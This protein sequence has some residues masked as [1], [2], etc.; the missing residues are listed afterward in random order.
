MKARKKQLQIRMS[1]EEKR[2]AVKL[3]KTYGVTVSDLVRRLLREK[4][5]PKPSS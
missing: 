2:L 5:V 3:A 4:M 1:A